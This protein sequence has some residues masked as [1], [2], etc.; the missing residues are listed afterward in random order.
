ARQAGQEGE[1]EIA[2]GLVVDAKQ[3]AVLERVEVDGGRHGGAALG[4]VEAAVHG[5]RRRL[6]EHLPAALPQAE[7]ELGVLAEG[8]EEGIEDLAVDRRVEER[9]AAEERGG[10]GGAEDPLGDAELA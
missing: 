2:A 4:E 5:D 8:V 7:A 3:V 1:G 6:G 10:A 9:L